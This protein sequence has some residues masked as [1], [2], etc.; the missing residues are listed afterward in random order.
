MDE[1]AREETATKAQSKADATRK[2]NAI[3]RNIAFHVAALVGAG[4]GDRAIFEE[5]G[6]NSSAG[7][8]ALMASA[9]SCGGV[10]ELLLT[11]GV[12]GLT[13][14]YGRKFGFL[15]YP[16][17]CTIGGLAV[18]LFPKNKKVVWVNRMLVWSLGAI[19]GGIAHSGAAISD[20]ASGEVLASAYSQIFAYIGVGV[21]AG[22]T[23]GSNMHSYFGAK[24]SHLARSMFGLVQLYHNYY[25]LEETLPVHQRNPK[26]LTL[27]DV[28]PLKCLQLFTYSKGL[29][30]AALAIPLA[31]CAEGKHTAGALLVVGCWLLLVVWVVWVVWVVLHLS[32]PSKS[33]NFEAEQIL[34]QT[35]DDPEKFRWW[36]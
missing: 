17:Y 6:N 21:L 30:L 19:F 4:T 23:I 32:I 16:S 13:D 25:Y 5:L 28:N 2:A 12:G 29:S 22:L 34:I 35:R 26:P 18:F 27:A 7:I 14:R 8:V 15:V 10:L 11:Q 36:C 1:R 33:L 31:H 24:Y 20:L 9:M 3:L